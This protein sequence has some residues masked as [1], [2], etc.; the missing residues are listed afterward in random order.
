MTKTD[1][2]SDLDFSCH[3]IETATKTRGKPTKLVARHMS[4]VKQGCGKHLRP[5]LESALISL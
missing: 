4:S 2:H 5:A 1:R 3:T